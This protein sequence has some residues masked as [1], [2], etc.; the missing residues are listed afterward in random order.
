MKRFVFGSLAALGLALTASP[1]KADVAFEYSCSRHLSYT[2][3][4]KHRCFSFNSY[5]NPLGCPGGCA[6]GPALWNALPAY[7]APAHAAPVAPA[8]NFQ[9]PA[10]APAKPAV[11]QAG[12]TYYGQTY[13]PAYDYSAGYNY[14]MN[15]GYYGYGAGYAQAP[16][17]WY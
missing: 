5:A 9:A 17:Y 12:Y 16:N 15:Y 10:P 11:Q 13:A 7:A 4:S 14:Y 8:P 2:R 1:V 6:S 3:T